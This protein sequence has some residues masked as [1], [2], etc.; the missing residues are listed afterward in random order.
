M[1]EII[2]QLKKAFDNKLRLGIM[3]MLMVNDSVDFT[4][5]RDNLAVTD[6]NLSAHIKALHK[7]GYVDIKKQFIGNKPNT[8]YS[9]TEKGRVAFLDHL[10]YLEKIIRIQKQQES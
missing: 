7:E 4:T 9:V 2:T 6:G 5:L 10:A 8:S 3:S 1:K